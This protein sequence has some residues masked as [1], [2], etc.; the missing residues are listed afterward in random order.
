MSIGRVVKRSISELVHVLE[1]KI[2]QKREVIQELKDKHGDRKIEEI[3]VDQILKGMR[4]VTAQISSTSRLD[5]EKGIR[6]HGLSI[7]DCQRLLPKSGTQPMVESMIW[8]LFTGEIPNKDQVELLRKDLISRSF[9]PI[10]TIEMLKKLPKDL[11]PMTQLSMGVLSLGHTSQFEKFYSSGMKKTE[12]WR[13]MLEDGLDLIS[14]IPRVAATIYRNTY[15]NG[16]VQDVRPEA[17]YAENF[18]RGLGW[19]DPEFFDCMRL[20]LNIHTD[21][22]AGNVSAHTTHLVGSTLRDVF[23]SYSA[24]LNALAGPLHGLANQES[25]RWL[26]DLWRA[27][28]NHP[29]ESEIES[30]ARGWLNAGK[31]IPGYGHAV[32][33]IP[34]PRFVAQL[35]FAQK[36]LKDDSLCRIVA[37]CYKVLPGVLR[38]HGKAKNPFPNVDA[39]SGALMYAYGMR[40]YDYY[41]VLFGVARAIGCSANLTWDRALMLPLERP[42]SITLSQLNSI[43]GLK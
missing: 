12:Y 42:E 33:R 21:H 13:A 37:L 9:L 39:H 19:D 25:L 32:L 10:H 23:K 8:L 1:G 5:P 22:E 36:H 7:E 40:V 2:A 43:A 31:A 16:Q 14:K 29:Q 34:D 35:E 27:V 26:M 30:F 24:G 15:R 3:K 17:D 11:H 41:T 38:E 20:Y 6:F 28:G 18:A 4:G